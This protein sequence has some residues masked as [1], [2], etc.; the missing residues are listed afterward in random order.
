[1]EDYEAIAESM[2]KVSGVK[3]GAGGGAGG[4]AVKPVPAVQWEYK[5]A[6]RWAQFDYDACE[7]IQAG[8]AAK[9]NQFQIQHD[10]KMYA[11]DLKKKTCKDLLTGDVLEIRVAPVQPPAPQTTG[12]GGDAGGKGEKKGLSK[13]LPFLG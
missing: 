5:L 7:G 1:M 13:W 8:V 11:V 4:D 9:V 3:G 6:S 2:S 10:T 12:D